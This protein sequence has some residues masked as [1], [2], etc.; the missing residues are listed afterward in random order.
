MNG[1]FERFAHFLLRTEQRDGLLMALGTSAWKPALAVL[2]LHLGQ[3]LPKGISG[4][5]V[6]HCDASGLRCD[7]MVATHIGWTPAFDPAPPA[8]SSATLRAALGRLVTDENRD[9]IPPRIQW[10]LAE[11]PGAAWMVQQKDGGIWMSRRDGTCLRLGV[12]PVAS[13]VVGYVREDIFEADITPTIQAEPFA[14]RGYPTLRGT[15]A[16]IIAQFLAWS[17]LDVRLADLVKP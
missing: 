12:W 3:Y 2:Y 11:Q 14:C 8:P 6:G 13:R 7:P 5:V 17:P 15:L 1:R 16:E 9:D 4:A 10:L